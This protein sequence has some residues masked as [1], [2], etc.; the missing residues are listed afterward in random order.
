M[1]IDEHGGHCDPGISKRIVGY[2]FS[3]KEWNANA[4]LYY[5]LYRFYDPNLQ[6]WSNHD[7]IQERGGANLYAFVINNPINIVDVFGY[8]PLSNPVIP[9][10]WPSGSG[11]GGLIAGVVCFPSFTWKHQ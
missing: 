2:R 4:G 10:S 5:Y 6:R 7:P 9:P 1:K 3:S 8:G 11:P